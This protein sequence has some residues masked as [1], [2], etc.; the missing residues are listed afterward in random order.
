M[1]T[2]PV[3][4]APQDCQQLLVRFAFQIKDDIHALDML[5]VRHAAQ[6]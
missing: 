4:D 3:W 1:H 5:I 6:P 2:Y